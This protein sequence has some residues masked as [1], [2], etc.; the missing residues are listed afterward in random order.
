MLNE[1][2]LNL[3]KGFEKLRLKSYDDR[4]PSADISNPKTPLAGSLT[5]GYGHTGSDVQR[6]TVWTEEQADT[7]L[8]LDLMVAESKVKLLVKVPL[9]PN[10]YGALTSFAFNCGGYYLNDGNWQPYHLWSL[11]NMNA[12]EKEIRDLWEVTAV[13]SKGIPMKGLENRR[14][15]ECDLYFTPIT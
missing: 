14:L 11:I 9:N 4:N 7:V 15:A 13:T 6:D 12:S 10:Q 2:S 8:N 3:I 5:I 1:D